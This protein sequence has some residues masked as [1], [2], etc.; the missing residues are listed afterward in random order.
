MRPIIKLALIVSIPTL[1]YMIFPILYFIFQ[2]RPD[3]FALSAL[4]LS[5]AIA[6]IAFHTFPDDSTKEYL[7]FFIFRNAILITVSVSLSVVITYFLIVTKLLEFIRAMLVFTIILGSVSSGLMFFDILGAVNRI[8]ELEVY[9]NKIK[10]NISFRFNRETNE[11]R[12]DRI[13]MIEKMYEE[14]VKEVEL[15][16]QPI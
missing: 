14:I 6:S 7:E 9:K 5:L 10:S 11:L 1:I 2:I 15:I 3:I 13:Q 16:P 8:K 12:D 4:L